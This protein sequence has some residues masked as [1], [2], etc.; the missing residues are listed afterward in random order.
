MGVAGELYLAG[1]QLARG[2]VARRYFSA[3]DY[4]AQVEVMAAITAKARELWGEELEVRFTDVDR[5]GDEGGA[6]EKH[7]LAITRGAPRSL[8]AILLRDT[9][10]QVAV[11]VI[12]NN[13]LSDQEVEQTAAGRQAQVTEEA[14]EVVV[15]DGGGDGVPTVRDR[16]GLGSVHRAILR[17][18]RRSGQP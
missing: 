14:T 2:Y 8:R 9:N 1:V 5:L 6:F 17:V 3:D 15:G 13:S 7:Y 11:S 4:D 12:I 16:T 18:G 10:A